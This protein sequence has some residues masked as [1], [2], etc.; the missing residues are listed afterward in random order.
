[1]TEREFLLAIRQA[2]LMIIDALERKLEIHPRTAEY[3][4]IA[5]EGNRV[6]NISNVE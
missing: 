5:K 2:L 6:Y 4:H 1:M 3:K